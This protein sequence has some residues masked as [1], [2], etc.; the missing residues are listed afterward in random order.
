MTGDRGVQMFFVISGFLI[1]LGLLG[2]RRSSQSTA[3]SLS[4]FYIRRSLRIFP[5]YYLTILAI[6]LLDPSKMGDNLWW[7]VFY[8]SNFYSIHYEKWGGAGHL[9]SLAV[10]EQFYLIW[11]FIIL[12]VSDRLLPYVIVFAI[13][14]SEATKQYWA[15]ADYPWWYG[16]MH[17]L[18]AL[19]FLAVG[20]LLSY[21]YSFHRDRLH[22]LLYKPYAGL[23]VFAI[24]IAGSLAKQIPY[25]ILD[26]LCYALL[27]A[28]IIG[29]AVF[30]F[31]GVA[32]Y[33]LDN[34]FLRYI[35]TISYCIYLIH[36]FIP[37]VLQRAG[38]QF[39]PHSHFAILFMVTIALA[40]VSWYTFERQILKLKDRFE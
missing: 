32:G 33:I 21:F 29:R 37:D 12:F 18:A 4:R 19:D 9:W 17:P 36:P 8:V 13:I 38:V 35:G 22:E 1:T 20:A 15:L 16:Y 28:W 23:A 3:I 34:R 30:S 7:N 40:S 27:C 2:S 6:K 10:E 31:D 25:F 26:G 39:P 24:A 5:I 11:P 14:L